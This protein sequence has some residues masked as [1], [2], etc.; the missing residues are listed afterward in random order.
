M[1]F[2]LEAGAS[3]SVVAATGSA[4]SSAALGGL[5]GGLLRQGRHRHGVRRGRS[6]VRGG[7]DRA[8]DRHELADGLFRLGLLHGAAVEAASSWARARGLGVVNRGSEP[9][10]IGPDGLGCRYRV[11]GRYRLGRLGLCGGCRPGPPA[12]ASRPRQLSGALRPWAPRTA[13]AGR[14]PGPGRPLPRRAR[15]PQ[16]VA[17]AGTRPADRPRRTG[18]G[19]ESW[20][21]C[22]A[23]YAA[24]GCGSC[25]A[26][27]GCTC[28]TACGRPVRLGRVQAR[29]V[30]RLSEMYAATGATGNGVGCGNWARSGACANSGDVWAASGPGRF[31]GLRRLRRLREERTVRE[32]RGLRVVLD[33]DRF[34]TSVVLDQNRFRGLGA[35]SGWPLRGRARSPEP[36]APP[37]PRT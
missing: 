16:S 14:C 31:R 27:A 29:V 25:S 18:R 28:S 3:C 33:L 36:A 35:A 34:R 20:N 11:R 21:R 17:A 32:Q 15:V 22:S 30:R 2:L 24:C 10:A 26:C 23:W 19:L 4:V 5:L 37:A 7:R 6:Q 8:L 9:G 12:R 13:G 1:R